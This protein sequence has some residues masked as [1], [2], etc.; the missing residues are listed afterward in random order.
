[1]VKGRL[2]PHKHWSSAWLW[3]VSVARMDTAAMV[4]PIF[5]IVSSNEIGTD[6]RD[7]SAGLYLR[8]C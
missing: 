3:L 6:L 7:E 1:M 2:R 4:K 8:V 5:M